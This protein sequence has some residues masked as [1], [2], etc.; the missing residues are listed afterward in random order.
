V[1]LVVQD[2]REEAGVTSTQLGSRADGLDTCYVSVVAD[3]DAVE[4]GFR[5]RHRESAN[6]LAAAVYL[7]LASETGRPSLDLGP[8]VYSKYFL[9]CFG[10]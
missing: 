4:Q 3:M 1:E 5:G 8:V 2:H 10:A 6:E 7:F 9:S